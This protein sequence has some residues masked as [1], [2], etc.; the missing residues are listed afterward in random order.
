MK[1][2]LLARRIGLFLLSLLVLISC[3][4]V[5]SPDAS[6]YQYFAPDYRSVSIK[7]NTDTLHLSLNDTAIKDIGTLNF[8]SDR[9]NNYLSVCDEKSLSINFYN[10]ETNNLVKKIF[11]NKT[12]PMVRP[13]LTSVYCKN[14]DSIFVSQKSKVLFLIDT[15]G[16]LRSR[17]P[18]PQQDNAEPGVFANF[19]PVIRQDSL[20]TFGICPSYVVNYRNGLKTWRILYSFNLQDSSAKA[21]YGMPVRYHNYL[22]DYHFYN[23]S[24]CENERNNLVFSFPAD[25]NIYE[26]DLNGLNLSY[27]GKSQFQQNDIPPETKSELKNGGGSIQYRLRDTYGPIF[28]DPNE[29]RYLR[30]FLSKM[31][32]SDIK[33]KRG[34]N[35]SVLIFNDSLRLIGETTIPSN[36]S[37]SSLFFTPDGRIYARVRRGDKNCLHFVR[38][39]YVENETNLTL[40]DK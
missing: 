25:S 40:K 36:V 39:S 8:F 31:A 4:T 20:V 16:K 23:Y 10:L 21:W 32:M 2:N 5:N 3:E 38:F 6:N 7:L 24:Y 29:R 15:S 30:L 14:F 18:F 9:G 12:L 28:F 13:Y 35:Q 19:R 11:L 33:S 34:R 37:F 26:T 22:Y 1:I 17:A 27:F